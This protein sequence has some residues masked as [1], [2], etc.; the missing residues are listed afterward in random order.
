VKFCLNS[1]SCPKRYNA[2]LTVTEPF[3]RSTWF[4]VMLFSIPVVSAFM[5]IS[6]WFSPNGLNRHVYQLRGGTLLYAVKIYRCHVVNSVS[7][8]R[9][10]SSL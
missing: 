2:S 1:N 7:W 3:D 6:E 9:M 8:P 10:R 5:F 4:L